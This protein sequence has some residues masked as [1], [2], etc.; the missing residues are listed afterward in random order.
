MIAPSGFYWMA[1][2]PEGG[3]VVAADGRSA[4]LE[5]RGLAVIDQPR[6]PALDAEATPAILSVKVVWTATS[7]RVELNDPGKHFLFHG[8]RAEAQAEASAEVPS[9]GFTW[10]SEPMRTSKA[11]FALIGE[12][13]NGRYYP[14]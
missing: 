8:W 1:R 10:K 9:T 13:R 4:T 14:G 6:W 11:D 3:L 5:L 12:E 2:V 7:D